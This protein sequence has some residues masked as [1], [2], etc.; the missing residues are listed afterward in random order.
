MTALRRAQR[1]AA[2]ER[3]DAR[4]VVAQQSAWIERS[5]GN[6]LVAGLQKTMRTLT[7]AASAINGVAIKVAV[8]AAR[9]MARTSDGWAQPGSAWHTLFRYISLCLVMPMP[10]LPVD[11][12]AMPAY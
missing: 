10:I 4:L 7:P 3:C 5:L 11:P 2:L 1:A 8:I 6:G 9:A 12:D